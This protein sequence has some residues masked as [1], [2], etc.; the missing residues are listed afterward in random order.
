MRRRAGLRTRLDRLE[1][2]LERRPLPRIIFALY[3][4]ENAG[5]IT[6]YQAGNVTVLRLDNE[7]AEA[8]AKRAWTLQPGAVAIAALYEKPAR[9]RS[10][11][12]WEALGHRTYAKAANAPEGLQI[13]SSDP[14]ALAGIGRRASDAELWKLGALPGPPERPSS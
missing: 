11:A 10:Q 5:E 13:E 3:P 8:C 2:R 9:T 14:Y 12:D 1:K 4:H 7:S 6:G